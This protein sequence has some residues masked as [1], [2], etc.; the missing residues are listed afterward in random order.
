MR[1]PSPNLPFTTPGGREMPVTGLSVDYAPN[2]EI[3]PHQHAVCQLIYG[4]RGVVVVSTQAAQWVVPAT[5]AVWMPAGVEHSVRAVGHVA[6]RTLYIRPTA[7]RGLP[8]QCAVVAVG[9]LLRE[10]ILAAV[11]VVPPYGAASRD[12]RLMRLLLDEIVQMQSL[13]LSLPST[14][15]SRLRLIEEA[16]K[17]RPDDQSTEVQ[18]ARKLGVDPKTIHRL[19]LRETGLSFGRWR[20]QARLLRALELLAKGERVL[21]IALEVGYSSPTAFSTMFQRQFG[22]APSAFFAQQ[23]AATT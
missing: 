18:W 14:T 10:L 20:Q 4:V 6:M 12:G 5:R 1:A 8:A 22:C 19:F 2:E 21:D 7:A 16:I 23:E 17:R 15:D 13:P 3:R 11:Q 9:P